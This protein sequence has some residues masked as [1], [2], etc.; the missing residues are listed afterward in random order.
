MAPRRDR[1]A[2]SLALWL[3][4]SELPGHTGNDEF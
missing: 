4:A 1:L 3:S 2:G